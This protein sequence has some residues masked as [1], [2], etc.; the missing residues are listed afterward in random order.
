ML[1]DTQ[2]SN[3]GRPL[4][5]MRLMVAQLQLKNS[6]TI[7]TDA[8]LARQLDHPQFE[9]VWVSTQMV[10]DTFLLGWLPLFKLS[11]PERYGEPRVSRSGRTAARRGSVAPGQDRVLQRC[12][13]R[14][15]GAHFAF[16]REWVHLVTLRLN[17]G[18][19]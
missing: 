3:A 13:I 17:V 12:W 5:S 9:L 11:W 7:A 14:G 16:S 19:A 10:V 8:S 1:A 15:C 6:L 4:L 2:T 18:I